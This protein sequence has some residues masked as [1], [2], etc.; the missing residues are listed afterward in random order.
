SAAIGV[1]RDERLAVRLEPLCR[2]RDQRIGAIADG[3]HRL[4]GGDDELAALDRY[5]TAATGGIGLSQLHAVALD[6]GEAA[7]LANESAGVGQHLEVDALFPGIRALFATAHH[8][9]L[10]AAVDERDVL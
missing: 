3:D 10:G 7:I 2:L 8:L 5:G 1:G 4:I 6:T 9:R